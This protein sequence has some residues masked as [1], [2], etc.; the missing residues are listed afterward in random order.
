MEFHPRRA[1]RRSFWW[2]VGLLGAVI[3]GV[4]KAERVVYLNADPTAIVN[5]AGQDPT[6]NSYDT[7]GFTPGTISG[8]PGLTEA[9]RTELEFIL[10]EATVPFDIV[11]TWERPA[12]G[13]Y[14][15]IVM[16]TAADRAALFPT[17]ACSGAIGLADCGDTN[18]DNISFLFYGCMP[19][20]QQTD[21]SR[22]AFTLLTGAGFGW[23]LEN[24]DTV[25]QIGGSYTANGVHFGNACVAASSALCTDHIGCPAGQQNSTADLNARIGPRVD[26]GPPTVTITSPTTMS[27][28]EGSFE[29]TADVTDMF[30]GLTVTLD[31]LEAAQ[32]LTD[33]EPPYEWNLS[34]VPAGVWTL[35]VMAV[36]AD[37][38]ESSQQV[39][40][41]VDVTDCGG[42]G[43]GDT[44]STGSDDTAGAGE[45]TTGEDFATSGLVDFTT[46]G[47]S[48]DDGATGGPIDPTVPA[49]PTGFGGEGAETGC[50]CRATQSESAVWALALV[51]LGLRRRRA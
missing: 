41:C 13:P 50:G 46:S 31:I 47:S 23:G 44:G 4:A 51:L 32:E 2:G 19:A 12:V 39:T 45:S 34:G 10:K 40:V 26:D 3:P 37:G 25:G 43:P 16:G 14:D 6:Q 11:F 15:M 24:L 7:T 5:T 42:A 35:Q 48:E 38:N 27:D 20:A 49:N 1:R 36:D 8:W 9:Q 18:D 28:V 30:G 33:P 29:V 17:S 21:M 22:V